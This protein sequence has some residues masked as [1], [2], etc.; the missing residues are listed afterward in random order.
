MI[1]LVLSLTACSG[2]SFGS[3]GRL[4]PLNWFGGNSGAERRAS[5]EPR[6]GYAATREYRPLVDQITDLTVERTPTGVIITA[7][8]LPPTQGWFNAELVRVQQDSTDE[9]VFE[10]RVEP[11]LGTKPVGPARSRE[12]TAGAFLS[13]QDV[14]GLGTIR[15]IGAR[16][17]QSA[18]R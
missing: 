9:A 5:L 16:N 17:T 7:T 4:N 12:I 11:P 8:A 1:G 3:G 13:D 2:G 18:R 15:V 10:F 14:A 6:R